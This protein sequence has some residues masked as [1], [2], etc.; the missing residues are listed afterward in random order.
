MTIDYYHPPYK[1][2][3]S[4]GSSKEIAYVECIKSNLNPKR[5]IKNINWVINRAGKNLPS[6]IKS[7]CNEA[8]N[9]IKLTNCI[10]K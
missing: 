3:F 1:G 8:I 2:L 10:I 9:I 6:Y 7:K 5:A 4:K